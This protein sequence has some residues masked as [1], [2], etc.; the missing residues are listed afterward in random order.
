MDLTMLAK[1]LA[2]SRWPMFALTDPLQ[3]CQPLNFCG[4]RRARSGRLPTHKG[5]PRLIE[6]SGRLGLW[7]SFQSGHPLAFRFLAT[8]S[9]ALFVWGERNGLLAVGLNVASL[10]QREVR[11]LVDMANQVLLGLGARLGQ[12][13]ATAILVRAY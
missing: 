4:T 9:S 1:A 11:L 10:S 13:W 6:P 2:P 5:V 8:L 3:N 12:H 7:L